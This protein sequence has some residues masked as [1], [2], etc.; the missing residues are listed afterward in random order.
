MIFISE[1]SNSLIMM[2]KES[3]L[4]VAPNVNLEGES[5]GELL[6]ELEVMTV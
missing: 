5:F 3:S 2:T 4:K 6:R 1:W